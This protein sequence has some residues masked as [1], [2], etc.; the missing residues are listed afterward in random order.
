MPGKLCP[1]SI[2][3]PSFL[4]AVSLWIQPSWAAPLCR[5][6]LA[7]SITTEAV[8]VT[9]DSLANLRMTLDLRKSS[10]M[11]R[12]TEKTLELD[13]ELKL[14]ELAKHMRT[15]TSEVRARIRARIPELQKGIQKKEDEI[16]RTRD[17]E[18]V[19]VLPLYE[20]TETIT[21]LA[22]EFSTKQVPR[23][24][25][26]V[27]GQSKLVFEQNSWLGSLDL[28]TNT[29][30][31]FVDS[32]G[33]SVISKD[34]KTVLAIDETG[35]NLDTY[36]VSTLQ[37]TASVPLD[38]KTNNFEPDKFWSEMAVNNRGDR[39]AIAYDMSTVLI[40]DVA[41]GKLVGET[42]PSQEKEL[43]LSFE[44]SSD[45]ELVIAN[46]KTLAKYDLQTKTLVL[47]DK[48]VGWRAMTLAVNTAR[49]EFTMVMSAKSGPGTR[50]YF[51]R[52]D[53]LS[54]IAEVDSHTYHHLPAPGSKRNLTIATTP[55]NPLALYESADL[56][57][58]IFDFLEHYK[59]G[60]KIP[61]QVQFSHD[62]GIIYVFYRANKINTKT[63]EGI[64]VWHRTP[65]KAY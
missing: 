25:Q 41:T 1:K 60:E 43:G 42:T 10:G 59:D 11:K 51:V 12:P 15:G 13:Y 61:Y 30:T 2:L 6:I 22:P 47:N 29:A 3:L 4:L 21:H 20:A 46:G 54:V 65:G 33:A 38:L 57:T 5:E 52:A 8:N 56:T 27:E 26:M 14:R 19:I 48:F 40:F 7:P 16:I 24:M 31:T 49:G 55:E 63:I 37:K 34:L 9:I 58:P 35:T 18:K 44:F 28:K 17:S 53:N 50:T 32:V 23:W 39:V 45:S 36:S 62:G 64:D